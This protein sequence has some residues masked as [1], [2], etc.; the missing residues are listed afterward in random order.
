MSWRRLCKISPARYRSP[1]RATNTQAPAQMKVS[2]HDAGT[3][4]QVD[5][6][7]TTRKEHYYMHTEA[8][9]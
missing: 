4:P 2:A 3:R 5:A 1:T 8:S 7:T 9:S 6:F